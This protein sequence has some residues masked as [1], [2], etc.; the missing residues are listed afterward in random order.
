MIRLSVRLAKIMIAWH[1]KGHGYSKDQ[2]ARLISKIG[3]GHI[4]EIIKKYGPIVLSIFVKYILPLLLALEQPHD[5]PIPNYALEEEEE[6]LIGTGISFPDD[7]E[8]T[9]VE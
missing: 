4:W 3:D 9:E 7:E 8:E 1:M 6:T 5:A 2:R